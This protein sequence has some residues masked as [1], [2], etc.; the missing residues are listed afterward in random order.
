MSPIQFT[1]RLDDC[2]DDRLHPEEPSLPEPQPKIVASSQRGPRRMGRSQS[3]GFWGFT[4][5]LCLVTLGLGLHLGAN[6]QGLWYTDLVLWFA[7]LIQS[8]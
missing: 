8:I 1:E 7:R 2:E 3:L 4:L 6:G 5:S